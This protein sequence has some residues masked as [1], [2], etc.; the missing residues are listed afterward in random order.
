MQRII[1]DG[2]S[3]AV[4]N[5]VEPDPRITQHQAFSVFHH[6]RWRTGM[7][8]HVIVSYLQPWQYIPG[9]LRAQ[10]G[11]CHGAPRRFDSELNWPSW[12]TAANEHV[13]SGAPQP[14]RCVR[15]SNLSQ[16]ITSMD[17]GN[18]IVGRNAE[19]QHTHMK[20]VTCLYEILWCIIN[21]RIS[22]P[23]RENFDCA[24]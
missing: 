13:Q 12:M 6:R 15:A 5:K 7:S 24:D 16:G 19:L 21:R 10:Q 18:D 11:E 1:W 9:E 20:R 4:I 14:A 22:V 8:C 23:I 3:S 2:C 17:I